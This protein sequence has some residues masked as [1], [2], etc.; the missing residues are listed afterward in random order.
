M[1]YQV[2]NLLED[3][4]KSFPNESFDVIYCGSVFHLLDEPQTRT[5]AQ[6]AF[7]L[8]KKTTN[9]AESE[10]GGEP[11]LTK[12]F[13]GRTVGVTLPA[14]ATFDQRWVTSN[15]GSSFP[16]ADGTTEGTSDA[17][18]GGQEDEREKKQLRYLHTMD[19]L[20]KLL[21]DAGFKKVNVEI[22]LDGVLGG[23]GGEPGDELKRKSTAMF[24]FIAW[25]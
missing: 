20:K 10:G 12:V 2:A 18:K 24:A 14:P 22:A 7:K 13:F 4:E 16:S 1:V 19:S 8:L 11:K 5:L 9:I 23:G 15:Q 17:P 21:E 25:K 3:S 6:N